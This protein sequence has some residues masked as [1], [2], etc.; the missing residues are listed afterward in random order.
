M[1]TPLIW[2]GCLASFVPSSSLGT[3]HCFK[4]AKHIKSENEVVPRDGEEDAKVV[5]DDELERDQSTIVDRTGQGTTVEPSDPLLGEDALPHGHN[6]ARRSVGF[7]RPFFSNKPSEDRIPCTPRVQS[8]QKPDAWGGEV[9]MWR[10]LGDLLC[11][12]A[13]DDGV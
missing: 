13:G 5:V 12:A 9:T 3:A 2:A 6:P 11:G 4:A 7:C 10:S 1:A 8:E